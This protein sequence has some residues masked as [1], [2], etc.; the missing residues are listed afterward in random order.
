MQQKELEEY[1]AQFPIFQYHFFDPEELTFTE[2]VRMI[3][4]NECERYNSTWACPPAVGSVTECEK[5]CKAYKKAVF[6]STVAEISDI[7]DMQ[8]MLKTRM[9]H[10]KIVTELENF[11][12]KHDVDCLALSSDSCDICETCAW[13]NGPCRH[14]DQMHPC[15][16][17][18]GIVVTELAEKF[19]MEYML[20]M[21]EILWFGI[22]FLGGSFS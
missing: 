17:S 20:S 19:H 2:R 21:Q 16:E 5:K 15:I 7:T 18:H 12:K 13:P 9:G 22:L 11:L 6:F 14:L 10:E 4:Q 3:C 1:M 8:E